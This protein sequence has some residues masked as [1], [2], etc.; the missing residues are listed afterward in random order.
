MKVDEVQTR[1]PR[2]KMSNDGE[3]VIENGEFWWDEDKETKEKREKEE[4]D[5]ADE[6]DDDDDGV[7]L[8]EGNINIGAGDVELEVMN[9]H[10]NNN[11]N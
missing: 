4:R 8:I 2:V 6:G 1:H 11:Y 5:G 10:N 9:I 7:Q 3:I